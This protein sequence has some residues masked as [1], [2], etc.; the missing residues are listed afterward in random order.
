MNKKKHEKQ[1]KK[2]IEKEDKIIIWSDALLY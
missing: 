2:L 1:I